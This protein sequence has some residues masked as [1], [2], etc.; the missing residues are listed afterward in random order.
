MVVCVHALPLMGVRYIVLLH[1]TLVLTCSSRHFCQST[2]SV[3][4]C[5]VD[6]GADPEVQETLVR[7]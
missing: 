2:V 5:F 1:D 3:C 7:H 4:L 6:S